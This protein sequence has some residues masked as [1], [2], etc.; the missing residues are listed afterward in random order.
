MTGDPVTPFLVEGWSKGFLAGHEEEAY[1]LLRQNATERP[2]VDSPFNGRS[3][4]HYYEKL[5]YIP[6]GLELGTD[7]D[8]KGGDNDCVH[9]ASATLEYAAADVLYLH[10]L[11]RHLDRILVR[12]GRMELARS[13][14]DFLPARAL[15]DLAGWPEQDIF[16]HV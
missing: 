12:E 2:P 3:G 8:H 5:G 4:Q 11:K 14:F 6:F 10:D 15:L 13:C 1:A 9:P 7:C 16:A